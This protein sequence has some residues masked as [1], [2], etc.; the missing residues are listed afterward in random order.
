M[1]VEAKSYAFL[2]RRGIL[3]GGATASVYEALRQAIASLK[4]PPGAAIDKAALAQEFGVS[5]FPVSEALARLKTEGLVEI[6]PQRGSRV[7]LI[8]LA[9]AKENMFLR[10]ALEADAVRALASQIGEDTLSALKRNIR[11]QKAAVA[12]RDLEGF[13]EL[14]LE[15]HEILL[16]ALNFPRVKAAVETARVALERVRRLLS[17]SGRQARTLEEHERILAAL[18]ARDGDGA[19]GAMVRHLNAVNRDLESLAKKRPEIFAD[20]GEWK[21]RGGAE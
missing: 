21:G 3:R 15:F 13:H 6:E 5:R 19:A 2:R 12:A 4:L 9:D 1:N 10:R 17:A 8:R 11:Y 20:R 16:D 7:A 14:D 18:A